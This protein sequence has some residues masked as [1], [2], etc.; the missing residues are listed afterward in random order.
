MNRFIYLFVSLSVFSAE[1]CK[2]KRCISQLRNKSEPAQLLIFVSSSMPKDSLKTLHKQSQ[3][4]QGK[5]IFRGLIKNSFR[6]THAYF[7]EVQ[8]EAD[9]D[10]PAF[11]DYKI[12]RVPTFVLRK[13]KTYDRLEGHISLIAVLDIMKERGELQQDA[14][15]LADNLKRKGT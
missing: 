15:H 3:R 7:R 8:I 5:L 2:D 4:V 10:P 11:D 14:K 6:D 9:I 13:G 12:E 1:A